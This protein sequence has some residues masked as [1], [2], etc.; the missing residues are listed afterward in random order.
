MRTDRTFAFSAA[1]TAPPP[2]FSRWRFMRERTFDERRIL[3]GPHH[4]LRLTEDG[5]VLLVH[6]GEVD[7]LRTAD[8]LLSTIFPLD[9][10]ARCVIENALPKKHRLSDLDGN[11][12]ER[13]MASLA[14][15]S[16]P[17]VTLHIHEKT[18]A[19]GSTAA[20]VTHVVVP[21]L[22]GAQQFATLKS[23]NPH[24]L[25]AAIAAASL[26]ALPQTE[27]DDWLRALQQERQPAP[28]QK[29]ATWRLR[30]ARSA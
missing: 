13:L 29:P 16:V 4:A 1:V 17:T 26:G 30:F 28:Q 6:Q 24:A 15:P 19:V 22:D 27:I 2:V 11:D 12:P 7:G 21:E 20:S 23:R 18:Y 10:M 14:A 3:V 8:V 25:R 5:E 9:W